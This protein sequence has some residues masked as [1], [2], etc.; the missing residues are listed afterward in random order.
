MCILTNFLNLLS[1]S[2]AEGAN[3]SIHYV[4]MHCRAQ[5]STYHD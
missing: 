1:V 5:K 4:A 3:H 2:T